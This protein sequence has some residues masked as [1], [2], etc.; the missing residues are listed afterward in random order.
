[1]AESAMSVQRR[2]PLYFKAR[3]ECDRLNLVGEDDFLRVLGSLSRDQFLRE[4]EPWSHRRATFYAFKSPMY[5]MSGEVIF[6]EPHFSESEKESLRIIDEA[7]AEIAKK[8]S[9]GDGS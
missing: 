5:T 3:A 7:I 6:S 4:S 2:H 9:I 8:Y 1:M